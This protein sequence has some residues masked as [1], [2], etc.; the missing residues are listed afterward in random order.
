MSHHEIT[1]TFT[2]PLIVPSDARVRLVLNTF[3]WHPSRLMGSF[4]IKQLA[5]PA[6]PILAA[7][8]AY[9]MTAGGFSEDAALTAAVTVICIVWWVFEPLPIPATSFI[10][11][12]ALPLFQVLTPTQVAQA[13]G[14][15][16]ILLLLGGF[17]L[18]T[19]LE[20][21]GAHRRLALNMVKAFGG[22]SSRRLVFG[23]MAAAA[24]LSMWISNTAT[25]LMLIPVA[26]AVV[27]KSE[28]PQ[29]AVP[30]LLG[31]AY[32]ASIGGIGTPIGTPPNVVFM[33]V[34]QTAVGEQIPFLTWMSWAL[35]VVLV[36]VP[37]MALWLTRRLSHQGSVK[38]PDVGAWQKAEVRV[39]MVFALT[40]LCWITRK[41]PFGG[42]SELLGLE[43]TNDAMVAL[44]AVVVMFL[45]PDG[46]G[47]KLLDWDTANK[48]PWGMLVLFGAGITIASAFT[49]SG[50]SETIGTT[51]SGL[52]TL[53]ILL[54]MLIICLAVTFL[55][56]TTSNTAT[57]TLLMPI[58]AAGAI[59]AAIDPKLL[60]I[61]AALSASCAFMLPVATAP[62]AI[63]FGTGRVSIQR[64]AREGFALNVL[65]A[66]IISGICY[67]TFT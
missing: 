8:T 64:M 34:Y 55:T 26:L 4:S 49:A 17:I 52:S 40:A 24:L 27:E 15:P 38:L 48:I 1:V 37:V 54:V 33:G 28:D 51:L 2:M 23:F 53:P 61:P 60:M 20:K 39:T 14:H 29:L 46:K 31:I 42:W 21:S 63:A 11:L 32:A 66:F 67:V 13:Y 6:G 35:P 41:Q 22:T 58:L 45:V 16:L 50:L 9:L 65:G 10:P 36:F 47:E 44:L 12:G 7:F 57:T 3:Q 30:L 5:L 19:A 62:N 18:A 59:G 43:M 25:T 56:E